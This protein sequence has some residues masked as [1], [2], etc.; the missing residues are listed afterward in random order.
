M[1][2][3]LKMKKRKSMAAFVLLAAVF[4]GI[5]LLYRHI[6]EGNTNTKALVAV[7][8]EQ[9]TGQGIVYEWQEDEG[10]ILT[11]GH[12]LSGLSEGE[13]C[14]VVFS[15]KTRAQAVLIYQSETADAAFLHVENAQTTEVWPAKTDRERFDAL[16]EGDLLY[17][18]YLED[19]KAKRKEGVL[20]YP[21]VYLEDFS[22]NMML[23]DMDC[24]MGMS[25]SGVY[26]EKGNLAGIVCGVSSD[27]ETAV[28]PLS[29]IES[30]WIM[31]E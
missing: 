5:F 12:I 26:D 31:A 8:T 14:E 9:Y 3:I 30:E 13:S 19:G 22:L 23:A 6:K 7:R 25:G 24:V 28:L 15:D 1:K 18:L 2:L 11:A 17:T 20:L 21:W 4:A 16:Q 29:V 10:Y 27:G